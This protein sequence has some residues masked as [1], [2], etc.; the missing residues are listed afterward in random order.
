MDS[1]LPFAARHI[2]GCFWQIAL[3]KSFPERAGFRQ[4]LSGRSAR[5]LSRRLGT[6][7]RDE[8]CEFP[9]VLG[10]GCEVE[11][12]AGAIGAS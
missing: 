3:K 5:E 4:I 8:L 10:G 12:V 2:D 9:E 7:Y 11:L 6:W 1:E